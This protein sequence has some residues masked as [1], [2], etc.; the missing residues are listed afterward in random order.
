MVWLPSEV[1]AASATASLMKGTVVLAAALLFSV[2][3]PWN[4]SSVPEDKIA[5]EKSG[6]MVSTA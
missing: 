4:G 6:G 5:F 1:A 2:S 3:W